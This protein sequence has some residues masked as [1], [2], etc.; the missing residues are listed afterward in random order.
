VPL[1]VLFRD[2]SLA[3]VDKPAGLA[4]DEDLLPLAAR[5]L[6]PAGG[7]AWPRIVHRLDRG[8]SGCL[9]FALRKPAEQA[10]KRALD[11][12]AVEKTYL[13]LVRGAPPDSMQLDT[14]YGPDPLDRRRST[15]RVET[16]RRARLSYRV[17]ERLRGAALVEVQLDTGRTHQIRV[18]LSE[19]G[20][21]LFGDETYGV[22]A[23][24]L[25]LHAWR[26]AFPH[27]ETGGRIECV[28][29]VP[30]ALEAAVRGLR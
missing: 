7:R 23:E 29:P 24:R 13:A 3:V 16:P 11:E 18:Q 26:L 30:E 28:A 5:E 1:A 6:A 4:V 8:T 21:P 17:V 15:T 14:P 10:L 20:F 27:P 19:T 25:M 2:S 12:G 9:L 22:P